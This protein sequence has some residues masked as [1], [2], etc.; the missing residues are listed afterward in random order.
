MY[1][2]V[3][4]QGGRGGGGEGEGGGEREREGGG[5][6]CPITAH[7]SAHSVKTVF[8]QNR[9]PESICHAESAF[10]S[11]LSRKQTH[12]FVPFIAVWFNN[13]FNIYSN[14]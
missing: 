8:Q 4:V 3:V 5:D 2:G 13:W 12:P 14:K 7:C 9:F 6:K 1:Q 11:M 10:Q